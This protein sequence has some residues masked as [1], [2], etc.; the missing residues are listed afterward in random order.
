MVS[1]GI[2]W[3]TNKYIGSTKKSAFGKA[4]LCLIN[5]QNPRDFYENKNVGV[6]ENTVSSQIHH[7]FPEAEYKLRVGESIN[8]VFNYTF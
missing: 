6:G 7:I 2:L 1:Q 5:S 4:V 8:S 3:N